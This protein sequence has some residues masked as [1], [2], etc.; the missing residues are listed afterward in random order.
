M[1][2]TINGV[3]TEIESGKTILD[4]VLMQNLKTKMYAVERNQKIVTKSDYEKTLLCDGDK[5]EIVHFV[6]GG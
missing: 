3:I 4:I 6:G 2:V 1:Q 5:I